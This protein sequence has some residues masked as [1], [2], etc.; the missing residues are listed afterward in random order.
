MKRA[1]ASLIV[2]CG[3]LNVGICADSGRFT[4]YNNTQYTNIA[5]SDLP[6]QRSNIVYQGAFPEL[7]HGKLPNKE[8]FIDVVSRSVRYPGPIALD[9]EA[10]YLRGSEETAKNHFELMK[11]LIKWAHQIEPHKKIG[12]Y[13]FLSTLDPHYTSYAKKLAP[14]I[15]VYFPSMYTFNDN[16]DEWVDRL[17]H[18]ILLAKTLGPMKP[19]YPYIWPQYHD[20]SSHAGEYIGAKFWAFQLDQ[21][22]RKTS[23]AVIWSKKISSNNKSWVIETNSFIHRANGSRVSPPKTST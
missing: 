8:K 9:F 4:I 6:L 13:G 1:I 18:Y 22:R 15:D 19:M 12:F 14:L 7:L 5:N 23:G 21:M 20:K 3:L 17:N 11:Q 2:A 16:R 10:I